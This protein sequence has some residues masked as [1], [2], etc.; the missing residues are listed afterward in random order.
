MKKSKL[1]DTELFI[2]MCD[3]LTCHIRCRCPRRYN[4]YSGW[5]CCANRECRYFYYCIN[6]YRKECLEQRDPKI[7]YGLK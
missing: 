2:P 6:H 3:D 7:L 1:A 5:R 4:D